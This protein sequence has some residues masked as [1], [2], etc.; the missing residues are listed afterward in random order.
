MVKCP[1]NL[2]KLTTG[3]D[4]D[5]MNTFQEVSGIYYICA[6]RHNDWV[7]SENGDK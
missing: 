7:D 5:V 6:K 2:P 3:D 1:A 4:L